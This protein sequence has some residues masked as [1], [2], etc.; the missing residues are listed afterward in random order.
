MPVTDAQVAALRAFLVLDTDEMAALAY[1]LGDRGMPGY[2]RLAEAA[3]VLLA[4]RR[5]APRF[6]SADLVNY[7]AAV[8]T[9]RVTD[10]DEFDFDPVVGEDVLRF[11]L[12]QKPMHQMGLEPQLKATIVLLG[13]LVETELSSQ[14]EIDDLLTEARELADRWLSAAQTNRNPD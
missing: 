6:N 10:G 9:A 8:R 12:G 1:Q 4:R 5:F 7:V 11:S 14:A 2:I 3:L 13:G